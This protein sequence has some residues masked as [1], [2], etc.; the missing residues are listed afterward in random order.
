[1]FNRAAWLQ[2]NREKVAASKRA[3]HQAHP[4]EKKAA[5]R[6]FAATPNGRAANVAAV[7]RWNAKHPEYKRRY[8]ADHVDQQEG[9]RLRQLSQHSEKSMEDVGFI[10][11]DQGSHYKTLRSDCLDPSE[12]MMR[13][14]EEELRAWKIRRSEIILTTPRP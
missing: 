12:L 13:R 3:W 4:E 2:A 10:S 8:D 5:K 11:L 9:R 1:M 14:E 6:K 7:L